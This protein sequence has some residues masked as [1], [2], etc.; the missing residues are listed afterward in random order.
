[1]RELSDILIK[2]DTHSL[3]KHAERCLE[4]NENN[5]A[6]GYLKALSF[7]YYKFYIGFKS[8]FVEN[9]IQRISNCLKIKPFKFCEEKS[10]VVVDNIGADSIGLVQQ[11]LDAL[12][13][14]EYRII[15][16]YRKEF[17]S[18]DCTIILRKLKMYKNAEIIKYPHNFKKLACSQWLHDTIIKTGANKLLMHLTE[19]SIE[20]C[21]AFCAL[22]KEI[23]R[24]RITLADHT[25]WTGVICSDYF[26]EFRHY[27]CNVSFKER[28]ITKERILYQPYY[29]VVKNEHIEKQPINLGEKFV[30]LS[31]GSLYKIV[32]D[33]NTFFKLCKG[34]LDNCPNAIILYAGGTE[35]DT[36]IKNGIEEFK[37]QGKF[38]PIGYR[39]DI[40]EVFKMCDAYIN[41]YPIAGGL[42]CQYAA[43]CSKPILN[44][45]NNRIE[46]CLNQKGLSHFTSYTI[47]DFFEEAKRIYSNSEYRVKKGKEINKV[48]ISKDEFDQ[49][50]SHLLVTNKNAIYIEWN[51]DF[52]AKQ[53]NVQDA[54]DYNNHKE[55][56]VV[57]YFRL[58]KALD[59]YFLLFLPQVFISLFG[60]RILRKI[61]S[62][63]KL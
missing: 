15:Y 16:I 14:A 17:P 11:Y 23:I 52:R 31:G 8:D 30:F 3:K 42:M 47:D 39:K 5:A 60:Y 1:M 20:E 62:I 35:D 18:Q 40:F 12:I 55:N 48:I 58:Y 44:Y 51:K 32:D 2:K 57:F 19:W 34:I 6:M 50:L 61:K 59:V 29:P 13:K 38:I 25:F 4:K 21:V 24:Y 33:E 10:V 28:E 56:L 54:I 43:Q 46:E 7:Y 45:L 36:V 9:S 63:L 41:T 27:G 26:F 22:P 37:L 49:T 53:L